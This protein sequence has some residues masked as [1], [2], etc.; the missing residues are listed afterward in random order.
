[1]QAL[2]PAAVTPFSYS[3]LEESFGRAWRLYYERMGFEPPLRARV[4]RQVQGH[5]YFNLSLS[6]QIEAERAGVEPVAFY[7]NGRAMPVAPFEKPGFLAGLKIGRAQKKLAELGGALAAEMDGVTARARTWYTKT[8]ELRWSQA[9][10]LQVMEEI[11]RVGV[12]S[13]VAF[14]AARQTLLATYNR[15]VWLTNE[16]ERYPANVAL[17]NHAVQSVDE[18]AEADM[19]R[20]LATLAAQARG[21]ARVMA[22]LEAGDFGDWTR[23]LPSAALVRELD[24][25][26]AEY[27][28]RCVGEGELSRP[29]W[30]EDAIPVLH[31]VLAG[32]RGNAKQPAPVGSGAPAQKLLSA[33]GSRQKEAQALLERIPAMLALQSR[34]LHALSYTLAGTRLWA[35]AAGSEAMGDRRLLAVEDVF[36]F[37]LEE[38]KEM[39]TGE[40]NISSLEEIQETAAQ[41][42]AAFE[43]AKSAPGAEL[44]IGDAPARSSHGVP[45]TGGQAAGALRRRQEVGSWNGSEAVLGTSRLDSGWAVALPA[46]RG[47]AAAGGMPFDPVVAAARLWNIPVV[48]GLGAAYQT[49]V[50]GAQTSVDAERGLVT[51]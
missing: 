8:R 50:E 19:G 7:V 1:M 36:L 21:D 26:L 32:A 43:A 47:V 46:L 24:G 48:V 45:G 11:E 37:E 31:A 34:A 20:R 25:F 27:G 39:M 18:M 22:W 4:L 2:F 23:K 35:L 13:L 41:R 14:L 12:D 42:K 33:A 3:V 44:L 15:L 5:P 29:R 16:G 40:W 38:V 51:Q 10:L 17:I 6:A 30:Q 9:E 49:L 28:Q